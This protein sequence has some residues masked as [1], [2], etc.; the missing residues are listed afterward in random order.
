MIS[1]A[2]IQYYTLYCTNTILTEYQYAPQ[3]QQYFY[4]GAQVQQMVPQVGKYGGA[5]AQVHTSLLL[6]VIF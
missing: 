2:R 4:P 5:A 6:F 3:Q 1:T